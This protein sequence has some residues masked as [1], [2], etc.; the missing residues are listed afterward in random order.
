MDRDLVKKA[1]AA[2]LFNWDNFDSP[3]KKPNTQRSTSSSHYKENRKPS[4]AVSK[5]SKKV[6]HESKTTKTRDTTNSNSG[7][8]RRKDL[9]KRIE[10]IKLNRQNTQLPTI[11]EVSQIQ[12][13]DKMWLIYLHS[14]ELTAQ[15]KERED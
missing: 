8:S 2:A 5:Q 7:Q 6:R 12:K 13:V 3:L 4:S 15:N 14:A 11:G 9:N 1:E 10:S